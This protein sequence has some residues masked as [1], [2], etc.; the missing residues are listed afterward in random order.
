MGKPKSV[1]KLPLTSFHESPPS[2]LRIT[3]QCFCMKS[4]FGFDGCIAIRCTQWPTSA[5]GFGMKFDTKPLL[6]GFHVLP[7]SSVRNAPAAEIA[8]N[9]RFGFFG[10]IKIECKHIPP[11]PGCHFGPVSCL[12]RPDSSLH[13]LPPSFDS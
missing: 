10:S 8:T 3:S 11:A 2:S 7:P 9:I 13:D 1:G 5:V 4:V 6:I 12:R